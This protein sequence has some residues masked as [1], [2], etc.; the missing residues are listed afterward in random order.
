M[1]SN[2]EQVPGRGRC[3]GRRFW[4]IPPLIIAFVLVKAALVMVLW[5]AL[6]PDLFNGPWL[7]YPQALG[8]L[9]LAKLFIGFPRFGGGPRG[10]FGGWRGRHWA[11]LSAE[12]RQKLREELHRRH[13]GGAAT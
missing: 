12:E 6:I 8:L 4:F 2:D 7:G 9:V 13:E 3:H 5:N 1:I 11:R 10:R